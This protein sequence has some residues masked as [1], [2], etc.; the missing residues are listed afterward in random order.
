[1]T[2]RLHR[3]AARLRAAQVLVEPRH[4]LDE[5]ARPVTVIE[6]VHQN[7]VPGVL[8]GAG[9]TRQAED[10]GRAGDAGGGARLDRRGADFW[11]TH[12]QEQRREAVHLLVEQRLDRLRGNIAA[13]ET[14]AAGGDDDVDH[15]IGDPGFDARADRL[16][17][18]GDDAAL[19]DVMAGGDDALHQ[20]RPR[21]VVLERTGV[22][23]RQ[24]RDLQRHE[25]LGFVEPGHRYTFTNH[26]HYGSR[27]P[28]AKHP[29]DRPPYTALPGLSSGGLTWRQV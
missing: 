9:R 7:L 15:R 25:L 18:V 12:H 21:L 2:R 26:L 13:G 14:G 8:A 17:V 10:I 24:H 20:H 5:I 3:R 28:D 19:G 22:G 4:D 29:A 11:K 27:P 16:D 6:L 23:N 1:M